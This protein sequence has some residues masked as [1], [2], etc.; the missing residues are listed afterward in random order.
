[1]SQ[2]RIPVRSDKFSMN[3]E[4]TAHV[5]ELETPYQKIDIV[6]TVCFGRAL[7][8]D[9]HI[10]FTLMDEHAYHES[11]V[12]VPVHSLA[13]P[14]R[15][16]VVGGGDGGVVR[17]LCKHQSFEEIVMV[18][19]DKHVIECCSTYLPT[20]EAGALDDP[21]VSLY[22]EDAFPFVKEADEASFDL[23]VLDSTDVYEDEEGEISEMLF[24]KEFYQDCRRLL[25]K[26]G[27][28]VTQADNPVF[29]PYSL[30]EIRRAFLE[31]F[32]VVGDYW[33]L[34][35]SFGGYSAF[36]WASNGTTIPRNMPTPRTTALKYLN[37]IT[38]ALGQSKLPF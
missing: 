32:P 33:G 11:L 23:I 31:V 4:I 20:L 9:G 3:W 18:E 35:P 22:I 10:Q 7:L 1:M 16:L 29:C 27:M 19:I 6:D 12:Q 14:K 5:C 26:D 25:T 13:E 24:T 21:R 37:P 36:C 15:A 17:E 34:V 30:E 38:W 8:L 2:L 28:V